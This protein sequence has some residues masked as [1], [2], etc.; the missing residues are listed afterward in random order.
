MK[1]T[2]E[3]LCVCAKLR[4][5]LLCKGVVLA[6]TAM[7]AVV[8]TADDEVLASG[9]SGEFLVDSCAGVRIA[10]GVTDLAYSPAYSSKEAPS[11]SYVVLRKVARPDTSHESESVLSTC[12]ADASGDC[13]CALAGEYVRLVHELHNSG[14]SVIGESL[15][16]DV[17]F[18]YTGA[19]SGPAAFDSRTNSLQL[20]VKADRAATLAYATGWATN[21]ASLQISAVRLSGPGGVATG[22]NQVF[23]AEADASGDFV[24]RGLDVGWW[25]LSCLFNDGSGEAILEYLTDEF[26]MTGGSLIILW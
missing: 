2:K 13:E 10:R 6:V 4:R 17:S 9:T 12:A 26:K 22:T 11:G 16:A 8:A 21:A 14:G 7:S 20:A 5:R 25:R 19:D 15:V 23:S 1:M 18:A 24:L 3:K